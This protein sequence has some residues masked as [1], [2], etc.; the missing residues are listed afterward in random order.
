MSIESEGHH[1]RQLNNEWEETL[2]DVRRLPG[3]ED[4]MGPKAIK[5]LKQ[6]AVSGPIIIL[7]TTNSTCFA[8]IVTLATEVQCVKLPGM[9]FAEVEVLANLFLALSTPAFDLDTYMETYRCSNRQSELL[10]QLFGAREGN[11]SVDPGKVFRVLLAWLWK[12]LV[13]PVFDTLHFQVS[14]HLSIYNLPP[15]LWAEIYGITTGMVVSN[16]PICISSNPC[17]WPIW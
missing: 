5:V 15:H 11:I 16:R 13:K 10:T 12:D 9:N 2:K 4:F 1:L 8:L 17:S 3:F 14:R 6:T 7:T